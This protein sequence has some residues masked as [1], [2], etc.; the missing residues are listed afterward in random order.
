MVLKELVEVF[1][2]ES[3]EEKQSRSSEGY[4]VVIFKYSPACSISYFV[5]KSFDKWFSN[6]PDETK[7]VAVKINV[8]ESRSLSQEVSVK[9][10][11]RHES[12]QAIWLSEN[13]EVKW[14]AS[15]SRIN[16]EDLTGQLNPA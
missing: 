11:I 9:F 8:I 1:N 2:S 4:Q 13:G 16:T 10:N 12:P 6:L 7:L 14:Q 3:L 15:H 5:E